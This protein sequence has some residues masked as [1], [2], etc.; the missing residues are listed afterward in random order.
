MDWKSKRLN[1][2]DQILLAH[3][4]IPK[5]DLILILHHTFHRFSDQHSGEQLQMQL[6]LWTEKACS[7]SEHEMKNFMARVKEFAVMKDE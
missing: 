4:W 6:D 3:P 1:R 7:I 5:R 2:F